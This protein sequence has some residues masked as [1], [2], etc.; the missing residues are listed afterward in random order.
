MVPL[1][2]SHPNGSRFLAA[3]LAVAVVIAVL[4]EPPDPLVV[5]VEPTERGL[6]RRSPGHCCLHGGVADTDRTALGWSAA[7]PPTLIA[8]AVAFLVKN[9]TV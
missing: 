8:L 1:T 6:A 3:G 2:A 7:A 5:Q 4:V 9:F